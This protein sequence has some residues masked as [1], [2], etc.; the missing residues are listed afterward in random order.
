MSESEEEYQFIA[1]FDRPL[2]VTKVRFPKYTKFNPAF[3]GRFFRKNKYSKPT[4][5]LPDWKDKNLLQYFQANLTAT[6]IDLTY[7]LALMHY[8]MDSMLEVEPNLKE[9]WKSYNVVIVPKDAV[10]AKPADLLNIEISEAALPTDA[11]VTRDGAPIG[12]EYAAFVVLSNYRLNKSIHEES[13]KRLI[14][15]M[16]KKI[17][18]FGQGCPKLPPTASGW[19]Y[20]GDITFR[21]CVAAIDMFICKFPN[22]KYS[23]LSFL[24]IGSKFR[25]C[26]ALT[27]Y[28]YLR[29]LL[30]KKDDEMIY[31]W[32]D[33]SIS[34]ITLEGEMKRILNK[35][36]EI[37]VEHSYLPYLSDLRLC[38][39]SPYSSAVNK[40][41]HT[42]IHLIGATMGEQRSVNACTY[43]DG[44]IDVLIKNAV[45]V[46]YV[47]K[48]KTVLDNKETSLK[49]QLYYM[50][51][52]N[53]HIPANVWDF[54]VKQWSQYSNSRPGTIGE[55][56]FRSHNRFDTLIKIGGSELPCSIE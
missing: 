43:R 8:V 28:Y 32:R 10:K 18:H 38:D 13:R 3:P 52:P 40:Y 37:N 49:Q 19:T 54:A 42:W 31:E 20:Y 25:E 5:T 35:D 48:N 6:N 17:V 56:L 21:M 2:N 9:D 27:S 26:T 24:T 4:V 16:N 33:G 12:L 36:E 51:E 45:I 47:H 7:V 53:Y 15:Q 14:N 29:D 55:C 34:N 30:G 23:E 44:N 46:A 50:T 41:L 11:I 39:R 1:L 22:T